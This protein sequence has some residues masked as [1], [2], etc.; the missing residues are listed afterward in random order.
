MSIVPVNTVCSLA[1][2]NHEELRHYL[3]L[4]IFFSNYC[5]IFS[6]NILVKNTLVLG[7][8]PMG[9]VITRFTLELNKVQSP[10]PRDHSQPL[11][12]S[13]AGLMK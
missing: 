3:L 12:A 4:I 9:E 5:F 8:S 1:P 11:P 6:S 13:A 2:L 10:C 7:P